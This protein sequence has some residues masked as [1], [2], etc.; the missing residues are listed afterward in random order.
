MKLGIHNL[1]SEDGKSLCI[2]IENLSHLQFLSISSRKKFPDWISELEHVTRLELIG[3]Q[4][5]EDPLQF[6]QA[7]PNLLHFTLRDGYASEHLHFKEGGFLKLQ[8]LSLEA[9]NALSSVIIDNGALPLLE[10]LGIF[11][12]PQLK[13]VPSGIQHLRNITTLGFQDMSKDFICRI[14][15]NEGQDYRIVEHI[16]FVCVYSKN[17][18]GGYYALAQIKDM[19]TPST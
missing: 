6:L 12:T 18:L 16:P 5:I 1:K 9:L 15:P 4:L 2:V 14:I 19:I 8:I 10:E 7:L 13:E 11:D 3:S 17:A